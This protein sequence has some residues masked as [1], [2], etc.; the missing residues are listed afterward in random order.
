MG[1]RLLKAD[2]VERLNLTPKYGTSFPD[3]TFI[4]GW[5]T[6][7]LSTYKGNSKYAMQVDDIWYYPKIKN[8]VNYKL[9]MLLYQSKERAERQ[10]VPHDLTKEYVR[11]I[12]PEDNMCPILK[13]P[14]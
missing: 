6:Q 7:N 11:S 3:G 12:I 9:N 1:D 2:E 10:G 4:S 8:D 5:R 13:V 14:F